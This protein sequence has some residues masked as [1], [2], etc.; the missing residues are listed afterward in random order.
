MSNPY[1]NLGGQAIVYGLGNIVPRI[2]NYAVLTVY[3][4]RRFAPEEYGI[5]TELYAYVAILMVLLTYGMETGLF[6]FSSVNENRESV[7]TSVLSTVTLTSFIF[8]LFVIFFRKP[9]AGLIGYV[10]NPEYISYLGITLAMDAICAIIFAKLRIENKVR[11]FAL[12]K[13]INVIATI[14]FVFLFLEILPSVKSISTNSWYIKHLS[15][16]GVGYVFIANIIASVIVLIVLLKDSAKLSFNV[17]RKL[18][19]KILAYS[20]PLLVSGLAGIFNETIDRILLRKF[21]GDEVNSLYMLGIYGANYRIAVL[22]TIFIQMF[23]YAAEPFFFNMYGKS[24]ARMI[25]ANIL[26]YFV[27]FLMLIFL[28]VGLCIDFFKYFIDKDYHEGLSIVPVVLAANVLVGILFNVNMWYKLSGRTLYGVWI[29]GIGAVL[30]VVLN[31]IFIPK[32][33]YYSCAW[34][35]V[36]TNAIMLFLTWYYGSKLFPISYD[37]RKIGFYIALGLIFYAIGILLMSNNEWLNISIGIFIVVV[38][39]SVCNRMENLTGIFFKKHESK[40]S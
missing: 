22:M 17:N 11:R 40:D 13:I 8:S 39:F 25:Y 12:V 2:L 19:Q 33:G 34:I 26:K 14:F 31:I 4:T 27:I 1:K 23:R 24:D 29:T 3:Y 38:Y 10:D 37:V 18:M 5:I 36:L 15:N 16:I 21:S 28:G 20:L 7:Y 35:H 6:K 32:Y 9:V 30:T